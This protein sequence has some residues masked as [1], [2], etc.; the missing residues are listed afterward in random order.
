MLLTRR[1]LLKG[2]ASGAGAVAATSLATPVEARGN[3]AM[4][5]KALGL[6]Y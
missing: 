2:L 6:L 1:N 3:H 4:P 5:D